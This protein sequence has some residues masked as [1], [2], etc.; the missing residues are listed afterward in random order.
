MVSCSFTNYVVVGSSPVDVMQ[1]LPIFPAVFILGL[2]SFYSL[3]YENWWVIP[4][5][6]HA[7][8]RIK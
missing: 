7:A 4:K 2:N 8:K 1:E 5:K 3:R 6:K